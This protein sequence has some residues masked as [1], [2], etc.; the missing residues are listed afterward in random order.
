M[1]AVRD[2]DART[3]LRV[4]LS[5]KTLRRNQTTSGPQTLSPTSWASRTPTKAESRDLTRSPDGH[6]R[7][8]LWSVNRDACRARRPDSIFNFQANGA[9][10]RRSRDQVRLDVQTAD[11]HPFEAGLPDLQDV[12]TGELSQRRWFG[13]CRSRN[14]TFLRSL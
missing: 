14:S 1:W 8:P 4:G 10:S 3:E 12:I 5:T 2:G 9:T 13:S 6:G 7:G 11:D